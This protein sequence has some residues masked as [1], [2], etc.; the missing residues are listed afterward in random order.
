ML[1]FII[2]SCYFSIV[3]VTNFPLRKFLF[4]YVDNGQLHGLVLMPF[5]T[6]I[7]VGCRCNYELQFEVGLKCI[8][9]WQLAASWVSS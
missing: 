2:E 3:K 9:G 7:Q 8:L 5:I 4:F 1:N 6:A